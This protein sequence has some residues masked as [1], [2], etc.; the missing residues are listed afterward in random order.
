MEVTR[1]IMN[2]ENKSK[3]TIR[4]FLLLFLY[5]FTKAEWIHTSKLTEYGNGDKQIMA[6]C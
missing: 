5:N 2:N 6:I 4:V 3:K 1:L